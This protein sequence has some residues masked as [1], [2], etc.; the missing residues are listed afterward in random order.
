MCT[1]ARKHIINKEV[2]IPG[3]DSVYFDNKAITNLFILKELITRGRVQFD[4]VIQN[5]FKA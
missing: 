3:Y 5:V 2:D 1:N 4:Y